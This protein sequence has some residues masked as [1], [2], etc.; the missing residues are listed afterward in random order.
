MYIKSKMVAGGAV[1]NDVTFQI[2]CTNNITFGGIP[3]N[4]GYQFCALSC[5]RKN[6][7]KKCF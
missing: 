3:K 1:A 5:P 7:G 4:N 6:N 2:V